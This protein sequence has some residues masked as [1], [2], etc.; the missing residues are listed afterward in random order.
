MICENKYILT[1]RLYTY[2]YIYVVFH[3]FTALN[4]LE[5]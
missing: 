3:I 4:A 1:V 5:I 2:I